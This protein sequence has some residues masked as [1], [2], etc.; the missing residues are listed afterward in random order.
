[1][2]PAS[3]ELGKYKIIP[4]RIF[5]YTNRFESIR[6]SVIVAVITQSLSVQRAGWLLYNLTH[7]PGNLMVGQ[8]TVIEDPDLLYLM[9]LPEDVLRA[10]PIVNT[11]GSALGGDVNIIDFA[12]Y[13]VGIGEFVYNGL[14]AGANALVNFAK[15]MVDL[16]LAI[17]NGLGQTINSVVAAATK[18]VVDA[19]NAFVTWAVTFIK[20]TIDVLFGPIVQAINN[21]WTAYWQGVNPALNYM[22]SDYI[23]TGV[24]SS[25]SLDRLSN[26]LGG[27]FFL[28]ILGATVAISVLLI[29][30]TAV[31]NVF[32][33]LLSMGMSLIVGYLF[34][35]AFN[36]PANPPG[37]KTGMSYGTDYSAVTS[38]M[39][40][41]T[42]ENSETEHPPAGSQAAY[43]RNVEL[44]VVGAAIG[45]W[46][47]T[48]GVGVLTLS[49]FRSYV[50]GIVGILTGL[51]SA[52]LGTV[53]SIAGNELLRYVAIG[54]GI[55]S[56]IAGGI[57]IVGGSSF[58]IGA[59]IFSVGMGALSLSAL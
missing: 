58:E 56:I 52:A 9:H 42:I 16:G 45:V 17:I 5:A 19:F 40:K 25:Q 20:N 43:D 1:M 49:T 6:P 59:G 54:L 2:I 33:F 15:V 57:S 24:I 35:E 21:V 10:I 7:G 23:A 12:H 30:L 32:S 31:T 51:L 46:G 34:E 55:V 29:V 8:G 36:T 3:Q 53:S 18:V 41:E 14:E 22:K 50:A 28:I 27:D 37:A 47:V 11:Q 44:N 4:S 38:E 48:I 26:A 39:V 13:I